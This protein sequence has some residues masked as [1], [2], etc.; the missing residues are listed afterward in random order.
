MYTP[1]KKHRSVKIFDFSENLEKLKDKSIFPLSCADSYNFCQESGALK[2]GLGVAELAFTVNGKKI[3]PKVP[4]DVEIEKAYFYKK[5]D[6]EKGEYDNRLLV[7][8]SDTYIYQLKLNEIESGF[9]KTILT[10]PDVPSGLNY[11]LNGE[12]VF[13]F[14]AR[15]GIVVFRGDTYTNHTAPRVTSMCING[16]RLFIT[17]DGE[18]STLWFSAHFDPTNWYVSLDKAGF[19]D[20]Q[21]GLGKLKKVVSFNGSVYVFR[22]TGITRVVG[23]Y[24]QQSFYAQNLEAARDRIYS[25]SVTE[26]G[27]QI[28][29]LTEKGFVAFSGDSFYP[30]MAGLAPILQNV[31]NSNAHGAYYGGKLYM[32]VKVKIDNQIEDRIICYD[33]QSGNYYLVKGIKARQFLPIYHDYNKLA[34]VVGEN[35]KLGEVSEVAKCFDENLKKVWKMNAGNFGI[36]SE[37]TI[38]KLSVK[39]QGDIIID[40]KSD[41]IAKR[42]AINGKNTVQHFIVG[43]RGNEFEISI[44]ASDISSY[45]PQ[46]SFEI[47]YE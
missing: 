23:H 1:N 35:L 44:E 5:Y 45:I 43:V 11:K 38:S 2:D 29:Y 34:I 25:S 14:S 36:M 41:Y 15:Y 17:T 20:F 31:D 28:I 42:I 22:D 6:D 12:D 24:D 26:C 8:C 27:N 18:Q 4:L 37:K 19:I 3:V 32:A 46:L 21:D 33:V 16:E 9:E 30:I 47:L 7:Y 10:F 40:I 13:M 39:T